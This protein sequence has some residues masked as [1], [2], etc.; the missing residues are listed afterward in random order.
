MYNRDKIIAVMQEIYDESKSIAPYV[1]I[2]QQRPKTATAT[3][4]CTLT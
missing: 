1:L 4:D 3:M 2:A